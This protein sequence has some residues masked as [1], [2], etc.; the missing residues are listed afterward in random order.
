MVRPMRVCDLDRIKE[1]DR[2]VFSAE[3][4]Y[5]D[6]VY[7]RM[8]QS[9]LSVVVETTGG[10][11]I[12]YA[13]VGSETRDANGDAFGY[14]RSVAVHPDYRRRGYGTALLEA[15][16]ERGEH[17]IDLFVDERNEAAIRLYQRL[18]FQPAEVSPA[19]PQRRRMVLA[20]P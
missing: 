9:G 18:G 19:I 2:V 5:G 13:F 15:V 4:Q 8:P 17:E 14:V 1:I 6:T 11:V 3:E 20:R 16:I 12:G 10:G 7:E